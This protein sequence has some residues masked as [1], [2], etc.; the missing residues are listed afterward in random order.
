MIRSLLG[1]VLLLSAGLAQAQTRIEVEPSAALACL[2]VTDGQPKEPVY[3]FD[4]YKAD[5]PGRVVATVTLSGGT[6][7]GDIDIQSSEGD[8]AFVEASRAFL[9]SL[10]APCLKP[11]EK[12]RLAYDFVFTPDRREVIWS[13][14]KDADAVA[15]KAMLAC[16]RGTNGVLFDGDLLDPTLA[17]PYPAAARRQDLQGRVRLVMS[18]HS[19]DRE[20]DVEVIHR[21]AARV[22]A[23]PIR[24]WAADLRLPCHKG[25]PFKVS[26]V[27]VYR[28]DGMTAYGFRP[29]TLT[30]LLSVSKGIQQRRIELDTT[31]MGCPFRLKVAYYQPFRPNSVG[32]VGG[33]D[34]RRRPLL[35]LLAALELDLDK[36]GLDSVFADTAD[37]TVPCQRLNLNAPK[38]KTS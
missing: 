19:P 33:S 38:E 6:P 3:P 2:Q 30:G 26:L 15:R 8:P 18:F 16:L 4:Q 12:A 28:L 27:F 29:L 13:P 7:G 20:P 23:P 21:P 31:T 32:E 25:E 11:G 14:P 34:P 35:E 9:R 37:V 1:A 36:Q 5:A 24:A 22:F 17:P 10:S